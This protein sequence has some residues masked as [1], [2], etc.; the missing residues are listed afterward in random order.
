MD[1]HH[2]VA[3]ALQQAG[4]TTQ[5]KDLTP[6][7]GG[8]ISRA[9]RATTGQGVC[10]VKINPHVPEDFFVREAEGLALLREGAGLPVP[11]VY[12]CGRDYIVME[13]VEGTSQSATEE[14]LGRGLARQHMFRGRGKGFGLDSDNY[15]GRLPQ[16]NEWHADWLSFLREKRLGFQA[17]LAQ[18]KGYWNAER[19]RQMERLLGSLDRWIDNRQVEP[20]LLH[21]DLWGGN[22]IVGPQG[23]PYLIDPAAFFGDREFELAF[24]ELFGGFSSTFYAVYEEMYPLSPGY[25]ERRPLYQLYYLLVHLNLFGESYGAAVDRILARYGQR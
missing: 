5:L 18:E 16:P 4:D 1:I 6:V 24:T 10:F 11:E 15:I 12:G 14:M 9:Y 19:E 13:W 8:D 7:S 3:Q 2:L 25:E 23:Q 21:G 17:A 20:S 22:W